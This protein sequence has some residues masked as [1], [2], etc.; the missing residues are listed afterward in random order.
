MFEQRPH[1]AERLWRELRN[2][3]AMNG[4][5]IEIGHR[6]MEAFYWLENLIVFYEPRAREPE[7]MYILY[8]MAGCSPW[9]E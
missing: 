9:G 2:A 5:W 4:Y 8:T 1:K 7:P 6:E 3:P